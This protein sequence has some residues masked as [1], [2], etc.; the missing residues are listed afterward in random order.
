MKYGLKFAPWDQEVD[1]EE[2][3]TTLLKGFTYVTTAPLYTVVMWVEL[4]QVGMVRRVL[5]AQGYVHIQCLHWYKSDQNMVGPVARMTS[6]VEVCVVAHKGEI[7]KAGEQFSLSKDPVQR[8]NHIIGPCN[9]RYS[10]D[11][12]GFTIN[13]YEKPNYLAAELCRKYAKPGQWGVVAGFGA[14]GDVRGAIDSGL[15]LV[16]IEKDPNQFR[17]TVA[18]MRVYKPCRDLTMIITQPQIQG[19]KNMVKFEPAEP[20]E[21]TQDCG[22]CMRPYSSAAA[23]CSECGGM[24]CGECVKGNP[25]KCKQCRNPQDGVQL[26]EV[27]AIQ[28]AG[29]ASVSAEAV[30]E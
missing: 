30:D 14:G 24:A 15:H 19:A 8:H 1:T 26:P 11:G 7:L 17:A 6:A 13:A 16:A 25:L 3:M 4:G 10:K 27:P 21:D 28:A 18:N 5:E 12:N 20:G 22:V 2:E 29:S 23:E 9:R